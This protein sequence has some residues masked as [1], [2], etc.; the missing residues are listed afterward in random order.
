MWKWEIFSSLSS[1][2]SQCVDCIP[3]SILGQHHCAHWWAEAVFFSSMSLLSVPIRAWAIHIFRATESASDYILR[4]GIRFTVAAQMLRNVHRQRKTTHVR[5][6]E[7][8]LFL[9]LV[10]IGFVRRLAFKTRLLFNRRAMVESKRRLSRLRLL[11]NQI[12]SFLAA[13]C[14]FTDPPFVYNIPK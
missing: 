6:I 8:A 5:M 12:S 1:T 14:H 13:F 7:W 4:Y 11:E 9:L 3:W 2:S 10:Q